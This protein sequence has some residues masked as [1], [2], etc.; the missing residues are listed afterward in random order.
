QLLC[1]TVLPG[2]FPGRAFL[3][4][5]PACNAFP[6]PQAFL[7]SMAVRKFM[8]PKAAIAFSRRLAFNSRNGV[9]CLQTRI[10]NLRGNT[11]SDIT[12]RSP[13]FSDRE[14]LP[15]HMLSALR[16]CS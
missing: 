1:D 14:G 2:S 15:L 16:N 10:M 12:V 5:I 3:R 11:I 8:K 6:T 13:G 7:L 9:P 4:Q